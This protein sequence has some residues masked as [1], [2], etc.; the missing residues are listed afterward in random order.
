MPDDFTLRA[1]CL[2]GLCILA[3]L[4]LNWYRRDPLVCPFELPTNPSG[5]DYHYLQLDAIPTV[6][7]S[8]PVLSLMSAARYLY[9]GYRML[10]EGYEKVT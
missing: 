7:F 3:S 9:D 4:F 1:L 10:K 5:A 2:G 8:D 6:G